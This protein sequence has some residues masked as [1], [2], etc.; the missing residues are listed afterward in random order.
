MFPH[1]IDAG[2][3]RILCIDDN[4]MCLFL[5]ALLSDYEV[6]FANTVSEGLRLS[7]ERAFDL[8]LLGGIVADGRCDDLCRQIRS[9]N[10]HT[11]II[12]FSSLA[13]DRDRELGLSCGAQAYLIKPN[14]VDRL[15][16]TIARWLTVEELRTQAR[17]FLIGN[18]R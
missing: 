8:Y 4:E 16:P 18:W 6:V 12:F 3:K 11:P 13:Y 15:R 7:R 14:D 2:K 10:P 9:F 17:T 1:M 5:T